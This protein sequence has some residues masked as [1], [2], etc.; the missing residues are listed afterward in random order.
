[1]FPDFRC[2]WEPTVNPPGLEA[3]GSVC[4]MVQTGPTRPGRVCLT[5]E[6]AANAANES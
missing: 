4:E 3:D 5:S 1:M 6:D 2:L